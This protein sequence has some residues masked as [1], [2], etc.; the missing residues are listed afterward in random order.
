[1][2]ALLTLGLIG[3]AVWMFARWKRDVEEGARD[4]AWREQEKERRRQEAQV[5]DLTDF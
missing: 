3:G 2:R 5:Y 4:A 1:M